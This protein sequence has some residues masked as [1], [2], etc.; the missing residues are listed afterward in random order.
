[1]QNE[2]DLQ[3][4]EVIQFPSAVRKRRELDNNLMKDVI[5][6]HLIHGFVTSA[7]FEDETLVST[8]SPLKI[9]INVYNNPKRVV[10]ANCAP[11]ISTNNYAVNGVVH[12]MD[13]VMQN[14]NQTVAEMIE[15][16]NR[17]TILRRREL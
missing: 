2:V 6:M 5:G 1:L 11:I 12:L 9:R 8:L 7:D 4:P 10:T 16:D 17:F 3:A 14:P 13:R 15:S